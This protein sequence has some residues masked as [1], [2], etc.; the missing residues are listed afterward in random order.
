MRLLIGLAGDKRGA[1]DLIARHLGIPGA[2]AISDAR[3]RKE[4]H[5]IG[6]GEIPPGTPEPY[7]EFSD[8]GRRMLV[9]TPFTPRPFDHTLSNAL[10]HVVS[11]TNRGLHTTSSVNAQQNRLTPD[12]SD[13]VTREVPAEAIYLYDPDAARVVLADL[14][15]P[16]RRRRR[17]RGRV[18]RRRDGRLPHDQGD[19]GDGVDGLRPAGRA[20][21][22]LSP[23]RAQ[24][25]GP[26]PEAPRRALLPDGARGAARILGP[27]EDP[28]RRGAR[29]PL[30][31]E[32]AQHVPHRPGVRRHVGCRRAAWR[33][34]AAG[35][36]GAATSPVPTSSRAASRSRR[37]RP[38]TG[39][40]P[41]CSPTLDLPAG[42]ERTVVVV[43]GQADDRARAEAAIRKLLDPEAA[44]VALDETRG[45]W[46]E[47]DGHRL[48]PDRQPGV[49]PLP[50]LAEVPGAGRADLGAA[51]VLPGE[52]GVRLPRP[53]P[54][55][56][57]PH[58]DGPDAGAAA[59]PP[60]RRAAVPRGGRG[61][62]VP[63]A[64]GRPHRVRR[65]DPRLGQPPLA[66]LGGRRVRRARPATTRCSRSAS[67]YLESDLPFEPLPAGK[68]GMGFDPL[69]SAREDSIYR[70][71]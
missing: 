70:H 7:A 9:R 60:A 38:T 28:P 48:G 30:L 5:P 16:E 8:D 39:R 32:P 68:H 59:N 54:G 64:P 20:R 11:V 49:R 57:E 71:A 65:P 25:L 34:R 4:S 44:A 62:L 58:L 41:P 42:G 12:W 33:R 35:S 53:A 45:W 14:S 18:R 31:R 22:G 61:P 63:P 10:G 21:G 1:I 43:M 2:A 52:R 26:R 29:R 3:R 6:H 40:S 19:A 51:R 47:P 27:A 13:T 17:P 24:P 50:R 67:P 69:R 23:G 56:G 37:P 36:S 15:P 55:L 66:G 46:L